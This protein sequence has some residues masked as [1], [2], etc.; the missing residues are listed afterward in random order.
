MYRVAW[1][2]CNTHPRHITTVTE[3]PRLEAPEQR[4]AN[5]PSH[6]REVSDQLQRAGILKI[7]LQFPDRDSEYLNQLLMSLHKY[8]G[9][10]LP[11]THSATRGWFWDVRPNSTNFQAGKHQ[12]RSETMCEFP[13]HTDCSYEDLPP[14]YFALHVLQHDRFGGGTLS[15]LNVDRLS[16]LLSTSTHSSLSQPEYRIRIPLE[17]IKE[18]TKS[19]IVGSVMTTSSD[20]QT[21]LMR[22]R[23]DILTPMTARASTALDEIKALL[24]REEVHSHFVMHFTSDDLPKG[25]I[26][27]MDNRRWLHA[28]N[29]I[30]DPERHLRRVRWDAIPFDSTFKSVHKKM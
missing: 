9:H 17:F 2:T 14:R 21:A 16:E 23:E 15:V 5:Q 7:S 20:H 19:H 25:S 26:I 1:H 12:A 29:D 30:K 22:F 13:W 6:V 8:H 4:F 27:I 11:I 28:R 10:Q 3:V 18:P 24:K